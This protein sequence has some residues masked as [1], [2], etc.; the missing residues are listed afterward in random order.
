MKKVIALI[1]I[2]IIIFGVGY[3]YAVDTFELEFK[4]INNQKEEINLY[5][6]LPKEYI[7]FAI[8]NANLQLDYEGAD[9]I[10]RNM[11]PGIT[12]DKQNVQDEIYTE[13]GIEYVQ[14]LLNESEGIYKFDIL[15]N[16]FDMDMKFRIKNNQK[17]YIIHIDNFKIENGKCEIEYDYEKD[18]VK[19]PNK[20][21][22]PISA[23]IMIIILMIVIVIGGIAYI[24]GRE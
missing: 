9:T 21:V 22:I 11:I 14:I 3:V 8:K 5:L 19:Q 18:T 24:K 13:S 12:V 7:I 2:S 4:T 15:E 23:I 6:L 10:K 16:Y 20:I 1:F 17:D